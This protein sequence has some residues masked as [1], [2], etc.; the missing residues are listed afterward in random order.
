MV[1]VVVGEKAV[2][3]GDT[4]CRQRT[5]QMAKQPSRTPCNPAS[6]TQP[7]LVPP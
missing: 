3:K 7:L 1:V 5:K 2:V 4:D 6:P